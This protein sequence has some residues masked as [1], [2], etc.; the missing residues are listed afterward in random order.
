MLVF[1]PEEIK[2]QTEKIKEIKYK[3][4]KTI[5]GAL[6]FPLVFFGKLLF[7]LLFVNLII[8]LKIAIIKIKLRETPRLLREYK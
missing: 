1:V 5:S 4:L 3:R 8:I 7:S 2:S 6:I